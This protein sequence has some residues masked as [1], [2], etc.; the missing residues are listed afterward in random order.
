VSGPERLG[1]LGSYVQIP[2]GVAMWALVA[3]LG[4]SGGAPR[5]AVLGYAFP[6]LLAHAV[7]EVGPDR[8]AVRGYLESL[9]RTRP[10]Y[11]G[12]IGDITF[13]GARKPPLVMTRLQGGRVV[14]VAD[15]PPP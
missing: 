12:I 9:G 14:R 8:M 10:A 11:H 13:M 1:R 6:I 15:W 3:V 7:R 2:T 4:C 5:V